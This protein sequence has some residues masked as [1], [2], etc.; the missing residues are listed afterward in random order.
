MKKSLKYFGYFILCIVVYNF[1]TLFYRAEPISGVVRDAATG[2]PLAGAVV[3][4][5]WSSQIPG[6]HSPNSKYFEDQEAVTDAQGRYTIP[7]WWIKFLPRAFASISTEEPTLL[8]YKYGYL[9]LRMRNIFDRTTNNGTWKDTHTFFIRWYEPTD[10]KIT[11]LPSNEEEK[12]KLIFMNSSIAPSISYECSWKKML[13]LILEADK[14]E[15]ENEAYYA[16][17][18]NDDKYL[19]PWFLKE[20]KSVTCPGIIEILTDARKLRARK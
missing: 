6:F 2:Q 1:V 8:V 17:L 19:E 4:I 9:P 18:Y 16:K 7:G 5:N 13:P 12:M 11:S 15:E 14:Q 10:L 3:A 20:Q